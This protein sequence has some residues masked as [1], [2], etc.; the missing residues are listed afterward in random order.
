MWNSKNYLE[1]HKDSGLLP[2]K[3]L[4]LAKKIRI[5]RTLPLNIHNDANLSFINVMPIVW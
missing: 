2:V 4:W 1:V 5:A 3:Q